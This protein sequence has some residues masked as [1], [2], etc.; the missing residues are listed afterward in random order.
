MSDHLETLRQFRQGIYESFPYRRD[1]LLDLLDAL[2]SNERARS[3]V[4]LSLNPCFRRQYSALYKAIGQAYVESDYP[5]CSL[6]AYQQGAV[7][8]DTLPPPRQRPYQVFGLDETPNERLYARCL[9]DR[10]HIHRCT[11]VAAQRPLSEGHT[12]SVLAAFPEVEADEWCRWALPLQVARV[13]SVSTAIEVAHHQIAQLLS[14]R[15]PT[16]DL[17]KVLTV[18]SRYPTPAFLHGLR[19]YRDLLVIAR[20]RRNRSFYTLPDPHSSPTRPRWYGSR[21]KLNDPTTWPGPLPYSMTGSMSAWSDSSLIWLN[22][23]TASSTTA[24]TRLK[25]FRSVRARLSQPSSR[26][27]DGSKSQGLS[28]MRTMCNRSYGSAV[29][30]SMASYQ[31]ESCKTGM[32]ST[33]PAVQQSLSLQRPCKYNVCLKLKYPHCHGGRTC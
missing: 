2:S 25:A 21:F 16:N 5:V 12:Y 27:D 9:R 3:T 26:W 30:I 23:D 8:L 33:C 31:G 13:S 19:D 11:P 29:L 17:L 15:P 18:D 32:H 4:E 28:G 1:S 24:I 14:Y 22:T 20:V 7:L 10:Q 6:E